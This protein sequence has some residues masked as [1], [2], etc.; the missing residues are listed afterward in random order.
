MKLEN[1]LSWNCHLASLL[2]T[3]QNWFFFWYIVFFF[4]WAAMTRCLSAIKLHLLQ[5]QSLNWQ[6]LLCPFNHEINPWFRHRAHLGRRAE[7]SFS[8][9]KSSAL[10]AT[11]LLF[12]LVLRRSGDK[13]WSS[14]TPHLQNHHQM[15]EARKSRNESGANH[16]LRGRS[17][18]RT[19]TQHYGANAPM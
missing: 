2:S 12:I 15:K 4:T 3:I 1:T 17:F 6:C 9:T 18:H 16:L 10:A 5:L 8:S 14:K 19:T 7:V 11:A 13:W